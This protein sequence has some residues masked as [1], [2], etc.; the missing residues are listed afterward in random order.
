MSIEQEYCISNSSKIIYCTKIWNL[1]FDLFPILIKSNWIY[2][3]YLPYGPSLFFLYFIRRLLKKST[4]IIWGG[5]LYVYRDSNQ[6]IM[7]KIYESLRKK[8]IPRFAEVA[9]F[10]EGDAILSKKIYRSNSTY[11]HIL[12]PLPI[13]LDALPKKIHIKKDGTT[14]ILIGNSADPSNNHLE[15]LKL[16]SK[17]RTEKIR[18]ICP[19]SYYSDENYIKSII[20]MGSNLFKHNFIPITDFMSK[21]EYLHLLKEI[22][23]CLMN[24]NRQQALGNIIP[25]LYL[26][27]K[28]YI[29]SG[30][31]T[32]DFLNEIKCVVFDIETIKKSTWQSFILFDEDSA[33][34][35]QKAIYSATSKEHC[36]ELWRTLLER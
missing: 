19:L 14:T 6:S 18:I 13:D 20:T 31:T 15:V 35:N 26:G 11:R 21:N 30:I 12:Y 28:L 9:S 2:I 17:F 3:H 10:L 7:T 5:D 33:L 36:S 25:L 1:A 27:K 16:L 32:Y 23:I 8:I 22:D 4:W 24:H 34:N 29:K